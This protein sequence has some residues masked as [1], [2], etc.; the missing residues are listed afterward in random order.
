MLVPKVGEEETDRC[1]LGD[2]LCRGLRNGVAQDNTQREVCLAELS[3]GEKSKSKERE[4][5]QGDGPLVL[6]TIL[7]PLSH[8]ICN[9]RQIITVS[10]A[11]QLQ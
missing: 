3:H 8:R 5:L 10:V 7:L 11:M 9:D 1:T 4:R 6:I 2:L